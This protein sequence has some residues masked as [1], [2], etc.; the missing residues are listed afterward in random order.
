MNINMKPEQGDKK[1]I[2]KIVSYHIY[3]VV[4]RDI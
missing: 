3:I 4:G 1:Y 2:P